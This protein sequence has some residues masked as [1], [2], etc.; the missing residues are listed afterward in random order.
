MKQSL[1]QSL[2]YDTIMCIYELLDKFFDNWSSIGRNI[3]FLPDRVRYDHIVK[4]SV[5]KICHHND[6]N[7]HCDHQYQ[8]EF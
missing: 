3:L 8:S 2:I 4:F 6:R 7:G 1:E 5:E